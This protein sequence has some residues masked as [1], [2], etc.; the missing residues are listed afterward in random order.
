MTTHLSAEGLATL[1]ELMAA[2]VEEGE[3]PGLVTLVAR[4]D[5]VHVDVI[6]RP[7]FAGS[8]PLSRDAIFRIA[9]LTKPIA[10][11]TALSLVDEGVLRLDQAIDELLPELADRR[12][13]R[14]IDAELDDTV[15]AQRPIT[16]EDLLSYR[17]GF[18]SVM[19][20]P[21]SYPIQRAEAALGLQ[22]I[23]GPPWPPGS[24]DSDQWIAALGSLPL[25]CQP[26]E[27]WLYNTSGQVLGVLLARAAGTGLAELMRERI[28]EPLGM[29]DTGFSVAGD[30]LRR[31][32]SFYSPDPETGELSLIDDPSDSWWSRPPR[33][34]DASGWLVSTIDDYWT[35]VS[36]L[37]AG[38]SLLGERILSERSV[39]RTACRYRRLSR[40][41]RELGLRHGGACRGQHRPA[42]AVRIRLGRRLGQHV[43]H[44]PRTWRHRHPAHPASAELAGATTRVR[45][46]LDRR[47]RRR[48]RLARR[49]REV[50]R[51]DSSMGPDRSALLRRGLRLE[52]GTLGWNVVGLAVL[53]ATAIA[54]RS[55]ALAGFGLDS[56]IEIGASVV[57]VWELSGSDPARER[58][59]L[60]LIGVAFL[61]LASYLA[62][63]ASV[64]L[65][66]HHHAAQS[67]VGIAWTGASALVMFALAAGKARTGRALDNPV[68]I[69]E[70]RVTF[71]DG[72]L[73]SAV[74][75]G[76]VL[77][78]TLGW[79]WADPLAGFVIVVYGVREGSAALRAV[80]A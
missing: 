55:V 57:V 1:H 21:D 28:F 25:L 60:R 80:A 12:V 8:E 2:H 40:R 76:L 43:A 27:Q 65:A 75:A 61:A 22:S 51:D 37:L 67:P 26:G 54:A 74:L 3:L 15:P 19:A 17:M 5:D 66:V 4:G 79:W 14:A 30:Q 72:L 64:V 42:A 62:V 47:Q 11:A 16:V 44:Q 77:N 18:G 32:T 9:S 7:S 35:F 68:L 69:S 29:A 52:Y 71:V 46:L 6:G 78:A 31:L 10:A 13:L 50:I 36:M 70:G 41:A 39:A 24:L 56:L 53:A 45:R 23:G 73:A 48:R 34:P 63:Q 38:G 49:A 20:P 58:R 59:A 33:F